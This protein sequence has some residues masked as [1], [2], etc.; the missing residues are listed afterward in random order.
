LGW[1]SYFA[2]MIAIWMRAIK[3]DKVQLESEEG[4]FSEPPET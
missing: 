3:E 4:S 2:G 1:T